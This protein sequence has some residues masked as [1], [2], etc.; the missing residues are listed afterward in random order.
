ME[1]KISCC[2]Q[3]NRRLAR[4]IARPCASLTTVQQVRTRHLLRPPVA[5]RECPE[6]NQTDPCILNRT[7]FNYHYNV[8]SGS[9]SH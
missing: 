9:H 5:D 6:S 4:S 7:C 3:A 1:K 2:L 8:S